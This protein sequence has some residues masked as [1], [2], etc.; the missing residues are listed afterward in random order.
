[1]PLFY[2]CFPAL[3]S[4][5]IAVQTAQREARRTAA[6]VRDDA[7]DEEGA[8]AAAQEDGD[9]AEALDGVGN[10][11]HVAL[12]RVRVEPAERNADGDDWQRH[13]QRHGHADDE[14]AAAG[15]P[16]MLQHAL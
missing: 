5:F 1:M 12:Q 3:F 11:H 15:A 7:P 10:L 8:V 6:V 14:A 2:L 9:E 4:E 16:P 13:D